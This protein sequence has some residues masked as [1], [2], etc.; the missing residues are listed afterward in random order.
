MLAAHFAPL[1]DAD[2]STL[3]ALLALLALP[4][5]LRRIVGEADA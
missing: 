1:S 4:A 3:L 5:L 2:R